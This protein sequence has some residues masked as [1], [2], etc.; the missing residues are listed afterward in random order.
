MGGEPESTKSEWLF[1]AEQ[2][3]QPGLIDDVRN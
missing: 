2:V 3:A 1:R